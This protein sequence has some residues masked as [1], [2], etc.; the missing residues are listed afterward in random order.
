MQNDFAAL[1]AL[2]VDARR[3]TNYPA[4]LAQRVAG[5]EKRVL[6]DKFGLKN[7]GVTPMTSRMNLFTCCQASLL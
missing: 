6:G 4:P 7:F 5:R 2:D 1:I 3:S